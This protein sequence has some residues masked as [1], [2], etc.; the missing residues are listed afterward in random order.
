MQRRRALEVFLF[1]IRL[2]GVTGLVP[3]SAHRSQRLTYISKKEADEP[4][5]LI[6]PAPDRS[7]R[8]R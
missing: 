7:C 6:E 5:S 1:L 8:G 3:P 4:L 2:F